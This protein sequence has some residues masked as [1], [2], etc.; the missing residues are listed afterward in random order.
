VLEQL[1]ALNG[2]AGVVL[3]GATGIGLAIA[4]GLA[5]C[6]VNVVISSRNS[7]RIAETAA[8]LSGNGGS[9]LAIPSDLRD[10][11]S[12]K[13]TRDFTL[14]HFSR[15]DI[16]IVSSGVNSKKP[17]LETTEEEF[18]RLLDINLTGTFRANRIF[19]EQMIRQGAGTIVNI[20]SIAARRG[21]LEMAAYNASKAGVVSLTESLACE[22]GQYGVR[23]NAIAPGPIRTPLN[24]HLLEMPG[25]VEHLMRHLAINRIGCPDELIGAALFLASDA[26]SYVTGH[27]L[28]VDGG[29]LAKGI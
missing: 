29:L 2:K 13:H 17:A 3:G 24:Q 22:W 16:L 21:V 10:Y 9:V 4:G 12:L 28:A 5:R 26:S 20:A 14:E 25:R 11:E 27:T 8:A 18:Q 7:E 6:G 15:I 19:G 1:Y 23:V